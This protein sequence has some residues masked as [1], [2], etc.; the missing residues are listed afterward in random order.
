MFVFDDV[1]AA[2]LGVRRI[3]DVDDAQPA[4]EQQ[5]VVVHLLARLT[6]AE[7]DRAGGVRRRGLRQVV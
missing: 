1:E 5:I 4:G 6:G 7:A 3:V 2:L